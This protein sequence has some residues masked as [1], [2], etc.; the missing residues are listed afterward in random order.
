MLIAPKVQRMYS[1]CSGRFSWGL[2]RTLG[3]G[4]VA[5]IDGEHNTAVREELEGVL[6]AGGDL[7]HEEL[8]LLT[9][10]GDGVR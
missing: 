9:V 6:D 5:L 8:M 7:F 4:I 10:E 2:L 3:I 1:P